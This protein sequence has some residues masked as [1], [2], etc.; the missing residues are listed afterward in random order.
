MTLDHL[1]QNTHAGMGATLYIAQFREVRALT[2]VS[3][4]RER[5]I[6]ETT[7]DTFR[8][9]RGQSVPEFVT[10]PDA[11]R[12]AWGFAEVRGERLALFPLDSKPGPGGRRQTCD[13]I[14]IGYRSIAYEDPARQ[15]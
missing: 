14:I 8:R 11:P 7:E 9:G 15:Y 1:W 6:V 13:M 4:D 12:S 2:V 10:D 5:G 3:V